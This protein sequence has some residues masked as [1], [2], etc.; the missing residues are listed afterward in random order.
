[1]K[2]K[3]SNK[4]VSYSW[5]V[6][7]HEKIR[8]FLLSAL[9]SDRLSQA[10][11]LVGKNGLGKYK[12]A[13]ELA[14]T[15]LCQDTLVKPCQKCFACE[16]IE[17]ES[18]PDLFL[19]QR[20]ADEKTGK[21]KK[22]ISIEQIRE[23][24]A[25]LQ[26]GSLL[27]SYKIA[28]IPEAQWLNLNGANSLLKVLEE[29]T[30]KTVIILITD[31]LRRMPATIASRCQVLRFLPVP[32]ET[33]EEYL[34]LK[35]SSVERAKKISRLSFNRPGRAL[36]LAGDYERLQSYDERVNL[37]WQIISADI[38]QRFS[39]SEEAITWGKDDGQNISRISQLFDDWQALLRDIFLI[40]NDNEI[41]LANIENLE[42]LADAGSKINFFRLRQALQ[43]IHQA[44]TYLA[45][46]VNPK[47]ILEN[48]IINL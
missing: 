7:G 47:L 12:I 4:I 19:V 30:P 46:N 33:I 22:D 36:E 6:C 10:Y 1:M 21:L 38:G 2:A 17:K 34:L 23:L 26:Q 27:N 40:K 41:F 37:F 29:P 35:G 24:K 32:R 28:I 31:D 14:K 9:T 25:R 45:Q 44:K 42:Q 39:L 5:D 20:L 16:A 18:H 8:Q 48:L 13:K 43:A 11:L 3:E 15:L